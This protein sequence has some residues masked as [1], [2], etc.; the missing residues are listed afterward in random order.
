MTSSLLQRSSSALVRDPTTR[1]SRENSTR[2]IQP[3]MQVA[4]NGYLLVHSI[5]EGTK[6]SL[7]R[8]QLDYVDIIF[9][10]QPDP[11]GEYLLYTPSQYLQTVLHQFRSR[12]PFGLSTS[13]LRKAGFVSPPGVC[14][15]SILIDLIR[16][17]T[18]PHQ[19]GQ[20]SR[21]KR[22]TVS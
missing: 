18:G 4:L 1:V 13:S 19:G 14:P 7:Q 2:W 21:S 5:I 22:H 8:L 10:H 3:C 9:A 16:H 20:Q 6:E 11:S 17:S 12:R 15:E